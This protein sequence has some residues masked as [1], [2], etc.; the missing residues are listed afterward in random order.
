MMRNRFV[1]AISKL[2]YVSDLHLENGYTRNVIP[3]KPY[4]LLGGDIGYTSQCSYRN[5]LT[6][7]S[8]SFDKVYIITGNHEYD[9]EKDTKVVE[10]RIHNICEM[11]P[12]LK[13]LQKETDLLCDNNI[14]IA[15]CTFWSEKPKSKFQYHLEHKLWLNNLLCENEDKHY[16]VATH[17]A[18]SFLC[19]NPRYHSSD[20]NYFATENNLDLISRPNFLCSIHGHTHYN[21]DVIINGKWF[22]SNQYG[23]YQNPLNKYSPTK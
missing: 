13:F 17:H 15:G 10:D 18:L 12:N 23:K 3:T 21:N 16:V 2:Q 14:Y 19:L 22:L 7:V 20:P 11:R 4:L 9:M 8:N 6:S 1:K 5:F